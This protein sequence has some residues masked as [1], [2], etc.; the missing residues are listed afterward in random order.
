MF[1]ILR[2]VILVHTG[3]CRIDGRTDGRTDKGTAYTALAKGFWTHSLYRAYTLEFAV[4]VIVYVHVCVRMRAF[5]RNCVRTNG[6][7][8]DWKRNVSKATVFSSVF[9]RS[10]AVHSS[11]TSSVRH[12]YSL[13]LRLNSREYSTTAQ[14]TVEL[15]KRNNK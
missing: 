13:K 3:L 6:V 10:S 9:R 4:R 7:L 5:Y 1:V 2:L 12:T 14:H 15:S 8:H 11:A